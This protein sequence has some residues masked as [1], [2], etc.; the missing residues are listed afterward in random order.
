MIKTTTIYKR[1]FSKIS[2]VQDYEQILYNLCITSENNVNLYGIEIISKRHNTKH[3]QL[4]NISHSKSYIL[5][6]L[7]FL[8]ENAVKPDVAPGI[9]SD[10]FNL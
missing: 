1:K 5:E 6:I 8:Y 2:N 7:K 9:I 3:C 4:I 10:I